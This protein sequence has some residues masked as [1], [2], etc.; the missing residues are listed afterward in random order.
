MG[1]NFPARHVPS[2]SRKGC[3]LLAEA[4]LPRPLA[5]AAWTPAAQVPGPPLRARCKTRPAN[6]ALRAI[7]K[8]RDP[9]TRSSGRITY[10]GHP[11]ADSFQWKC[12]RSF[13]ENLSAS[14]HRSTWG[15]AWMHRHPGRAVARRPAPCCW[16]SP[17]LLVGPLLRPQ[18]T[19]RAA[20][21]AVRPRLP[22]RLAPS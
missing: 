1:Q 7:S 14:C 4:P 12:H 10:Q 22:S 15:C 3:R 9:H 13:P 19:Q 6:D 2:V 18:G 8:H 16:S 5:A 21:A 11:G 20:P 17:A